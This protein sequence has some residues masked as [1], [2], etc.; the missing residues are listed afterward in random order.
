MNE[1]FFFFSFAYGNDFITKKYA[2]YSRRL[3]NFCSLSLSSYIASEF[4]CLLNLKLTLFFYCM[5]EDW[6]IIN[7]LSPFLFSSQ[8]AIF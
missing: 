3:N 6:K 8:K 1:M 4:I 5:N 7:K 2:I